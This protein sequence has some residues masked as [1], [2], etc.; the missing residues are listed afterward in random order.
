[1]QPPTYF[2]EFDPAT[3][4]IAQVASASTCESETYWGRMVMLPT[5]QVLYSAGK[6]AVDLYTPDGAPDPAWLP[7]ITSC[8]SS[9]R[10]GGEYTLFGRQINGLTQCSYYGNDATNATNYPIV[11]LRS[12]NSPQVFYCRSSDFSTMGL[13]TGTVVHSCRFLVPDFV[14]VGSYS[15]QVIANGIASSCREIRVTNE[16]PKHA[17]KETIEILDTGKL[18]LPKISTDVVHIGQEKRAFNDGRKEAPKS[19]EAQELHAFIHALSNR[20]ES[21]GQ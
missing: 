3:N 13:Q 21:A 11:R 18:E 2:F 19:K 6:M 12:V 14:P 7:T 8:P 1:F 5:G 17:F 10:P 20:G 9:V 15:I 16:E 4:S